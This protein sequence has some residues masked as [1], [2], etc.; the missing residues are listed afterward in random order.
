MSL[1]FVPKCPPKLALRH[2]VAINLVTQ[3]A[4][5]ADALHKT[6]SHPDAHFAHIHKAHVANVRAC[7]GRQDLAR[8]RPCNLET[9]ALVR[10]VLETHT[11][12]HILLKPTR[13]KRL[14]AIARGELEFFFT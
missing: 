13:M 12:A 9:I 5:V 8:I 1:P 2:R 14:T 10:D 6:V 3:I 4:R 7:A 11:F